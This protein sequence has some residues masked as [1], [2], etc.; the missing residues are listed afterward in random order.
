MDY[1]VFDYYPRGTPLLRSDRIDDAM[2]EALS[3]GASAG[4]ALDAMEDAQV[5]QLRDDD[6][7]AQEMRE[8]Y[9]TAGVNLVSP[10]MGSLNPALTYAEGV[11]RDLARWQ[12]RIDALDWM[13][14][15]TSPEA[16][17]AVVD[18]GHV[19]IVL[20]VQNGGAA[21]AGDVSEVD[22]LHNAGVQIVQLT[23]NSRNLVGTGCTERTDSGLSYHGV[24]V[25]ERLQERGM[26]VDLSHCGTQTT[27]DAIAIAEKPVA[28]THAFSQSL[29][30]HD[31]GK[32]DEE[33]DALADVDGYYGVV[34]VPFFLDPG[35]PDAEFD[36]FFDNIEYA[37]DRIGI[38]R[39][40]IGT[41]WG[42]WTPEIPEPLR[43]GLE[44][45]FSGMG[46]RAEHGV[47]VGVGYGPMSSYEDW[48]VIPE[49]LE[50]RG[51]SPEE[52]RKLLGENVLKFWER[53]R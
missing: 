50:E 44:E 28:V 35:N 18:D 24:D 53:A 42:S 46:F 25:V 11:R 14:K 26:V 47:E 20:N 5:D 8:A 22:V 19:G 3:G 49:G 16:A 31:R 39:V 51:F 12:A 29:A 43:S 52:Q 1:P 10:T 9:A 32:S 6:A 38:D 40:G 45:S 34:A 15:V 7:F 2:D 17:R 48:Q 30:A 37:V 41:D 4:A 13:Q 27:L 36:L 21:T 23:Y 33:L